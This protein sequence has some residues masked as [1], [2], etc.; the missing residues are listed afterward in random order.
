MDLQ[1]KSRTERKADRMSKRSSI[2]TLTNWV[3]GHKKLV[4]A[5]WLVLAFAGV[6]AMGPADRSFEQ[7][8]NLPGTEAFAANSQILKTYGNGGDLAPLVPVVSLP[9]GK[10][11]DSPGVRA[12]L[13]QAMAK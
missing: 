3:L 10:T 9:A 12:E 13:N 8:F 5:L 11:V 4:V 6:A 2:K 1:R 7:Q